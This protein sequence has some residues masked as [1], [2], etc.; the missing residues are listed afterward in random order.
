MSVA[1]YAFES[2]NTKHIQNGICKLYIEDGKLV[3]YDGTKT[4]VIP[5]E[6]VAQ[7]DPTINTNLLPYID[8]T[9][10]EVTRT[11]YT[12]YDSLDDLAD[13][14][15]NVYKKIDCSSDDSVKI[16]TNKLIFNGTNILGV[17]PTESGEDATLISYQYYEEHKDELKGEKGDKGDKGDTGPQGPQGPKGDNGLDGK[18]GEDGEE[19]KSW[20]WDL[21]NTGLS[22]GS[23]LALSSSVS[24]L[25]TEILALQTQIAGIA[26]N[27]ITQQALH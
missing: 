27:D 13:Y 8:P 14:I 2:E 12:V 22:G 3:F 20:I 1:A 18:D 17:T 5:L 6:Q 21:I 10:F 11:F 26:L 24:T 4:Y 9:S 19:A 23:Y 15:S 16:L 25:Q 7:Y